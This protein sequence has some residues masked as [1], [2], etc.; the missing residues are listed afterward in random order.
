MTIRVLRSGLLCT[1]QDLGRP[2]LQHLAIVPGGAID[3]T[4]HRIANALVGNADDAATLEF[5]LAGPELEFGLDALI[6]L[7][8]ARFDARIDGTPLPL[9]RPVL[10]RAG[11]RLRVGRAVEGSFGYLA[12]AGGIDVAPV[13]GSRS[14]ALAGAFGG[15]R[16]RALAPRDELPLAEEASELGRERFARL[17]RRT[18][19]RSLGATTAMSVPWSAPGLTLP[20]TDPLIVRVV[21]GVHVELFDPASRAALLGERWRVSAESNRMGYRLSG[22]KLGL[23][24]PREIVSQPVCFG[25]VQVPAGGQ[26]I[27]LMADRQTT[28]GYP[29][30]A[31]VIVAD[32][33]R[34][35]QAVPGVTTLRFERA[36][37][38]S[39]DE[40]RETLAR[41]VNDLIE[42]LRWEF[43]DEAH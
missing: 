17:E 22:P 24:E 26:P 20:A 10:V 27:A 6:A 35:A 38:E 13:L 4:S 33:P 16:G 21:D 40:A 8:G 23:V 28:G 19:V 29:R 1:V 14:T 2:G 9:S 15:F 12:V 31:E 7:H 39:A 41:R 42:R 34:L 5:A 3:A 18:A 11:A 25:T 36:T 37:L 32:V 30:I 43:G